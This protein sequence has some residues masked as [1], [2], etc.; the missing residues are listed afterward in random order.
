MFANQTN[1]KSG[2]LV[3]TSASAIVAGALVKLT[4]TGAVTAVTAVG[5]RALYVALEAASGTGINIAVQPLDPGTQLRMKAGTVSGTQ[6]AGVAVYLDEAGLI[7]ETSTNATKVG[8]AE[9]TFVTGQL[10]LVR[11]VPA[12]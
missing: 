4:T 7:C 6:N 3:K 10:V 5:D 9:E 11:P 8:Y 1:T 2:S 12:T